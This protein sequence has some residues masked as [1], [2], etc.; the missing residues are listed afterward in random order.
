MA[1]GAGN[2]RLTIILVVG[3]VLVAML[4]AFNLLGGGGGGSDDPSATAPPAITATGQPDGSATGAAA[5]P[6]TTAPPAPAPPNG[7]FD[8]F[9]TRNPFEPAIQIVSD[10]TP[11]DSGTATGTGTGTGTSDPNPPPTTPP[12]TG[13][14]EPATG[15]VVKLVDVFDQ[16]GVVMARVQVGS[17][18]YTV[19]A[20]QTFAVSYKV[21]SL[22]GT[23]GQFLYGDSPFSLCENE[24]VIK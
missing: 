17:T 6:S 9:A 3:G 24:E 18:Q 11:E 22:S 4:A 16:G 8:V 23:C 10:T 2:R 20:G 12:P 13:S 15:T 19:A 5:T 7:G 1:A 14:P 21:V